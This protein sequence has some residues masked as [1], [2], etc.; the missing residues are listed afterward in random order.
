LRVLHVING[1]DYSGAERVQDLLALALPKRGCDVGFACVK[2]NRFA[3]ARQ[4]QQTPLVSL[5]MRSRFDL[6]PIVRLA[7]HIRDEGWQI[8]HTHSARSVLL[9]APAAAL[10]RVPLVH[11]V[12]CQ[13][14]TE[15]E[16]RWISRTSG[17]VERMALS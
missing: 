3:A 9:G 16:R 5:P 8:V 15:V 1:E 11:H 6:R 2:P 14:S 12:H 17:I 7:G 10:A 13:T 4:S